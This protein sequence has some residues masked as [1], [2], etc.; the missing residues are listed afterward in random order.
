MKI[1][2]VPAAR[3]LSDRRPNGEA[4]IAEGILRR[5]A[6]RGHEITAYCERADLERPI[7]G[8]EIVE[9][10]AAAPTAALSR[11]AFARRIARDAATR[12][13]DVAHLLFPLSTDDGYAFVRGA[14]LV[15]GPM[16]VSWPAAVAARRRAAARAAAVLFD[17]A[18]RVLHARTFA[19]AARL[20]VTGAP[21]RVRIPARFAGKVDE[22]P[23]GIDPARF[24]AGP[25]PDEP[26]ILFYSVLQPRKGI[27]VLL[28]AMPFVLERV[29]RARLVVAGDDPVGM[30]PRLEALA[31]SEGVSAAV[32]FEGA[33]APADAPGVL[34]RARV[35]CQPSLGE[36]FGMTVLEAMATGRP[37][38]ATSAGGLTGIVVEGEGGRL[39]PPGDHRL[40]AD[41]L[42]AVLRDPAAA[43]AMGAF[44]RD[45]VERRFSIDGA[46]ERIEQTY[47]DVTRE[48]RGVGLA[49][50][51]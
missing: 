7:P 10:S 14:P 18:E 50:S 30:R 36:P 48:R 49:A 41:A 13:F 47:R 20:L 3:L 28:R 40:L 42:V 33:V 29:P 2:F 37:V 35:V 23:F 27:D 1:A 45:R 19:A 46:V 12:R 6:A 31:R 15:C 39:A 5:L 4:L 43:R 11:I 16:F 22:V 24:A 44:N 9:V 32:T 51:A 25:L 21:A 34:A 17:R 26:M 8:V 38:V